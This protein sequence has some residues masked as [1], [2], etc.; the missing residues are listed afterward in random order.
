M[1]S[2]RTMFDVEAAP[3]QYDNIPLPEPVVV[4]TVADEKKR[5]GNQCETILARLREGAV[6]NHE[7]AE[8]S[9]KYTGRLSDLRKQGHVIECVTINRATGLSVYRLKEDG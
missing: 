4:G 5:T 7:L 3:P 9:L 8:I 1:T 6:T 2:Q